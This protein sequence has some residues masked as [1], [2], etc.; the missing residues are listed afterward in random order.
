MWT[1]V[2]FEDMP[3][4]NGVRHHHKDLGSETQLVY[5]SALGVVFVQRQKEGATH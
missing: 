5:P 3:E 2:L 1:H 4:D